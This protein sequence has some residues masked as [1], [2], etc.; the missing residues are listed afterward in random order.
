MATVGVKGL[1]T[2]SVKIVARTQNSLSRQDEPTQI[3]TQL[4]DTQLTRALAI[5]Y[6]ISRSLVMYR[7]GS[8]A[9]VSELVLGNYLGLQPCCRKSYVQSVSV[10]LCVCMISQDV[11]A[12]LLSASACWVIYLFLLETTLSTRYPTA[13]RHQ[14]F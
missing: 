13:G 6:H 4:T 10:C 3:S 11:S 8:T 5:S 14:N 12:G 2:L 9:L 7:Y 1:S